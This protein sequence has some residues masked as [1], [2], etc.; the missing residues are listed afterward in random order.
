MRNILCI[1]YM[2][3]R[4]ESNKDTINMD[5]WNWREILEEKTQTLYEFES[6]EPL[7]KRWV[8]GECHYIQMISSYAFAEDIGWENSRN[9][10]LK[11]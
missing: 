2:N 8:E 6:T 9:C 10:V 3:Y 1:V 5:S 11:Q 7:V 4:Q